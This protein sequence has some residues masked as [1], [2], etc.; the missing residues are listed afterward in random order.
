[1]IAPPPRRSILTAT[2]SQSD[3][4][5][6][7]SSDAAAKEVNKE[8]KGVSPAVRNWRRA[9]KAVTPDIVR[10]ARTLSR[11][12]MEVDKDKDKAS[13]E[14]KDSSKLGGVLK[15]TMKASTS[16]VAASARLASSA[17]AAT[18]ARATEST[19]IARAANDGAERSAFSLR[20]TKPEPFRFATDSR[21]KGQAQGHHQPM[22]ATGGQVDLGKMLKSYGGSEASGQQERGRSRFKV[23][24]GGKFPNNSQVFHLNTFQ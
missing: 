15:K 21:S 9:V 5:T 13:K 12:T 18:R 6:V 8:A 24:V 14:G 2:P 11:R 20:V 4:L 1:M 19:K 17:T 23:S 7:P 22:K 3:Q 10:K 16:A